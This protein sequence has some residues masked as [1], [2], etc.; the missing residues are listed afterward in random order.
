MISLLFRTEK[1]F[2]FEVKRG[3]VQTLLINLENELVNT[4]SIYRSIFEL[5]TDQN[6][7][8]IRFKTRELEQNHDVPYDWFQRIINIISNTEINR[9]HLNALDQIF[10][11]L[12][13]Q[14]PDSVNKLELYSI[15]KD[16]EYELKQPIDNKIK[17][18]RNVQNLSSMKFVYLTD[19]IDHSIFSSDYFEGA[20]KQGLMSPF[21]LIIST[22]LFMQLLENPES[23]LFI[24]VVFL[25]LLMISIGIARLYSLIRY[26][27]LIKR[28]RKIM[29][30]V[31]IAFLNQV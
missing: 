15:F 28:Y 22:V 19:I 14:L 4:N 20:A 24:L 17:I 7:L 18:I 13:T 11:T 5:V 21:I 10:K 1:Q 6:T 25:L 30:D 31:F 3:S 2:D 12:N 26:I 23:D 27:I 16:Y 29:D 8:K 9:S